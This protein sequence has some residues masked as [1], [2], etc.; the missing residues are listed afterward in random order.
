[1]KGV[2]VHTVDVIDTVDIKDNVGIADIVAVVGSIDAL[3]KV[4][5]IEIL[6]WAGNRILGSCKRD[7]V[8]SAA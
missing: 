2:T 8:Y 1:M 6:S 3:G 5:N 4:V 7:A